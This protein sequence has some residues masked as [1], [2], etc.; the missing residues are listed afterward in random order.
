MQ[1]SNRLHQEREH[2]SNNRAWA[3]DEIDYLSVKLCFFSLFI[4]HLLSCKLKWWSG[5]RVAQ[6][7]R[8]KNPKQHYLLI[9]K[10]LL[11]IM[12][13]NQQ[14]RIFLILN[15]RTHKRNADLS[16]CV[17][18]TS[19]HPISDDSSQPYTVLWSMLFPILT[20]KTAAKVRPMRWWM[21]RDASYLQN[22][23]VTFFPLS[24]LLKL[25]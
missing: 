19:A 15:T 23:N 18:T 21:L 3:W 14:K 20:W 7:K 12:T 24:H 22:L 8:S 11:M 6:W 4:S 13:N 17:C 9:R 10:V 2:L 16:V 25:R 1:F 5:V